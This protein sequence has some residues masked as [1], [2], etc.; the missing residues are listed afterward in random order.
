[1][2]THLL[3]FNSRQIDRPIVTKIIDR[4][5]EIA[6]WYAFFD[7]SICLVTEMDA[8]KVADLLQGRLPE[9]EFLVTEIKSQ[10]RGGW[11]PKSVWKFMSHP[12][13]AESSAA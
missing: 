4:L 9:L 6:N 13:P 10:E 8:P 12:A 1:M 2:K 5:P 7:N 11:L 3:I